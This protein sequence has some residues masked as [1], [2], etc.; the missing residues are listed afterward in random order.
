M[1]KCNTPYYDLDVFDEVLLQFISGNVAMGKRVEELEGLFSNYCGREFAV[2]FHS[3]TSAFDAYFDLVLNPGDEVIIS[4]YTFHSVI[5][6]IIRAGGKPIYIDTKVDSFNANWSG[7]KDLLTDRTKVVVVTHMFG[8][9]DDS[10]FPLLKI[11]RS[12]GIKLVEDCAQAIGAKYMS[13]NVGSIRCDASIF[14]LYATK[15]INAI[16]GGIL[17]TDDP[18]INIAMRNLRNNGYVIRDNKRVIGT[19]R[20]M[21]D[22]NAAVGIVQ[23]GNIDYVTEMRERQARYYSD[24]FGLEFPNL[25]PGYRNAWHH[26]SILVDASKRYDIY[27]ALKVKGID[28]GIYYRY[29][30]SQDL[31]LKDLFDESETPNAE[32]LSRTCLQLPLGQDITLEDQDYVYECILEEYDGRINAA[33]SSV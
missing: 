14:S 5:Y 2:A 15:N 7:I 25:P 29:L 10:V 4:P 11:C 26:Y 1:I 13:G 28:L 22:I 3:A 33:N 16:E 32:N 9:P 12:R 27:N 20:R 8:I 6:S 23:F 18:N 19:N 31:L 21:S 30:A 24:I 17:V